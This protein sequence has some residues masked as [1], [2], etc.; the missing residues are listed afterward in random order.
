MGSAWSITMMEPC[1]TS[2]VKTLCPG[3]RGSYYI[4]SCILSLGGVSLSSVAPALPSGKFSF[5]HYLLWPDLKGLLVVASFWGF[6]LLSQHFWFMEAWGSICLF[7]LFKDHLCDFLRNSISSCKKISD[8][9]A[10]HWLHAP[11]TTSKIPY[12]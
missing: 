1:Q 2:I 12:T 3:N 10:S 7:E 4:R 11:L 5:V 8:L 6:P 9:F